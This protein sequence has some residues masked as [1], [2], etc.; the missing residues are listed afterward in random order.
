MAGLVE[1]PTAM[2]MGQIVW[3]LNAGGEEGLKLLRLGYLQPS[4]IRLDKGEVTKAYVQFYDEASAALTPDETAA[5]EWNTIIGEHT[6]CNLRSS[7]CGST[8]DKCRT[9]S[10]LILLVYKSP[11]IYT[12]FTHSPYM[13]AQG[14]ECIARSFL[15]P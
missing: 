13:S 10:G 12:I 2:E 3:R 6:L 1:M 8:P 4:A 5:L 15:E 14:R 9:L 7:N 11:R